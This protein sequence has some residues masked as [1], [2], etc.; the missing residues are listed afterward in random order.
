MKHL[1]SGLA[2]LLSIA[3]CTEKAAPTAGVSPKADC[4]NV[5]CT[6]E[7]RTITV[8]VVD[9]N[10]APVRLDSYQTTLANNSTVVGN[11]GAMAPTDDGHYPVISDAFVGGHKNTQTKMIFTGT[12]DGKTVVSEAY[13]IGV[14]CCHVSRI[15]GKEK[16]VAR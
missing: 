4:R 14:D 10:G 3:S 15:S 5:M 9:K 7:F 16:V 1:L 6:M 11:T 12:K 13:E 2:L 8:Q